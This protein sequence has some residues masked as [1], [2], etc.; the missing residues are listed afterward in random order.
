MAL[1]CT[2]LRAPDIGHVVVVVVS[3]LLQTSNRKLR[4]I[5]PMYAVYTRPPQQ[6]PSAQR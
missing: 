4:R 6:Q 5:E 1:A 3:L 2:L